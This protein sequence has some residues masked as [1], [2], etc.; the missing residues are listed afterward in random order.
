MA[1]RVAFG[2]LRS[3]GADVGSDSEEGDGGFEL[4]PTFD[5]QASNKREAAAVER[6]VQNSLKA[7]S[8]RGQREINAPDGGDVYARVGQLF[9][10]ALDLGDFGF[11]QIF[12][13]VAAS[14]H[15][16]AVPCGRPLDFRRQSEKRICHTGSPITES[17][18][19]AVASAALTES[20]PRAVASA[21]LS[22]DQFIEPRSLPLAVLIRR[23]D[24]GKSK[25]EK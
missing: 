12:D 24:E 13:P 1:E 15:L 8:E 22:V 5:R 6:T 21:A 25:I 9:C 23:C 11:R 18:P 14:E 2:I 16:W 4:R 19:R 3:R 10:R 20:V 7:R 17:V